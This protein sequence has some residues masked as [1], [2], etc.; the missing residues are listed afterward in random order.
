MRILKQLKFQL[1]KIKLECHQY[2]SKIYRTSTLLY[3][4]RPFR[5][6]A[7]LT[8]R[9]ILLLKTLWIA[10]PIHNFLWTYN[11]NRI[12]LTKD[13]CLQKIQFERFWF[14]KLK[15]LLFILTTPY[16]YSYLKAATIQE[17]VEAMIWI[18]L[19]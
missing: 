9:M 6:K 19:S 13:Q 1:K 15:I 17:W 18:Y 5:I 10:K 12:W 11:W 14:W 16:K 7:L 4:W 8:D 2:H 3:K